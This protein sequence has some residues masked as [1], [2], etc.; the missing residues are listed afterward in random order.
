MNFPVA[1]RNDSTNSCVAFVTKINKA[2]SLRKARSS[3]NTK[4]EKKIVAIYAKKNGEQEFS[5]IVY[6]K[7]EL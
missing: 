2:R 7:K 6:E 4:T 1:I 3:H 5:E